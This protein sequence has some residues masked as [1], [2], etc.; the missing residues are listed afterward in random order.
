MDIGRKE[1]RNPQ[2]EYPKNIKVLANREKSGS[3]HSGQAK[4]DP[5]SRIIKEIWIPAFVGMTEQVTFARVS[6]EFR[7]L[8]Y[9]NAR[10]KSSSILFPLL[11]KEEQDE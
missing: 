3:C 4:R 1:K 2:S 9:I 8:I 7:I 6:F 11:N 10:K 5:E